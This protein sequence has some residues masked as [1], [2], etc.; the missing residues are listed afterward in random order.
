MRDCY[1]V[2]STW[3]RPRSCDAS[4]RSSATARGAATRPTRCSPSSTGASPTPPQFIRPQERYADLV[5]SRSGEGDDG[6][7]HSLD[8]ELVLREGLPHPDLSPVVGGGDGDITTEQR[9]RRCC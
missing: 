1:D 7:P 9:G 4:G 5:V 8:A 2:R 3:R 6:D